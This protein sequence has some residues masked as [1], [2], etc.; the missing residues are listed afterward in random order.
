MTSCGKDEGKLPNIAFKTGGIYTSA[1]KTIAVGDSVTVG[2]SASKAEDKDYLK[3]FSISK[4]IGSA[5]AT[6][7]YNEALSG[8]TGDNYAHDIV[9]HGTVAETEKY[10]FTVVNKDGLVNTV[11]LTLTIN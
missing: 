5:A 3:T 10:T 4:A 7:I 6:E 8:S 9:I 2:I 11:S 1:D